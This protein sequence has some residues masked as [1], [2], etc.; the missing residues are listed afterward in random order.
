MHN[1]LEPFVQRLRER[2]D[3]PNVGIIINYDEID[4]ILDMTRGLRGFDHG[5]G[6]WRCTNSTWYKIIRIWKDELRL[7]HNIET[8]T[9]KNRGFL[10]LSD[11]EKVELSL[12]YIRKGTKKFIKSLDVAERVNS[13]NLNR[14]HKI[15]LKHCINTSTYIVKNVNK[16]IRKI[17]IRI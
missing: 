8:K 1:S 17:R 16:R 15:L 14:N 13:D 6:L 11:N 7:L 5:E 3:V 12:K 10:I 9:L 2:F 4:E